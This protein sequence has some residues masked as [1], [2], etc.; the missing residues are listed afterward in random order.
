M[1]IQ[2]EFSQTVNNMQL[3]SIVFCIYN[4]AKKNSTFKVSSISAVNSFLVEGF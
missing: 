4:F 1:G 2:T 3:K